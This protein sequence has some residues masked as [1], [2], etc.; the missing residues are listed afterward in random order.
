MLKLGRLLI[1]NFKSF[2]E[3]IE[4]DFS[5]QDLVLF[6]GP[7]GFGK[8]TI[9]DAVEL[10]LTGEIKRIQKT[11]SKVKREHVLKRVNSKKTSIILEVLDGNQSVITIEVRIDENI[12]GK[13]GKIEN[14]KKSVQRFEHSDWFSAT[15]EANSGIALEAGRLESILGNLSLESTFSI[16][17]YIQQEETLHFLKLNENERHAKIK[18]LFGTTDETK[19]LEKLASISD[20]LKIKVDKYKDSLETKKK[21]LALLSKP[22]TGDFDEDLKLNTEMLKENLDLSTSTVVQVKKLKEQLESIA[23]VLGNNQQFKTQKH[24]HLVRYLKKNRVKLLSKLIKIGYVNEYSKLEKLRN[25]YH[26]WKKSKA[27]SS[28]YEN[29]IKRYDDNPNAVTTEI[30][31]DFKLNFNREYRK[32]SSLIDSFN[33]LTSSCKLSGDLVNKI[34]ENRKNLLDNYSEHLDDECKEDKLNCPLCGKVKDDWD[35][36]IDEYYRQEE[37]FEKQLDDNQKKLSDVTQDLLDSF[38]S[39]QIDK[40]KRYR[41]RYKSYFEFDFDLLYSSKFLDK[42]EFEDVLTLSKWVLTNIA[43]IDNFL[44]KELYEVKPSYEETLSKLLIHIENSIIPVGSEEFKG[45]TELSSDIKE[46][47]F[48]FDTNGD[49]IGNIED[50]LID[51]GLLNKL[52]VQK[53]DLDYKLKEKELASLSKEM[54]KIKLKRK[55]V[56]DI[57][58]I[59]RNKIKEFERNIAKNIAIPLFVYSSKILQSR[60]EGSGIF[61]ITPSENNARSKGFMQFSATA[62]DSHDAWNTMSSGQLSGLVIS[63]MLAMNKVYPT[64]LFTL[65]IDDPVQTMDEVNMASFVQ[66]MRYEF[67]HVQLLISTH[68]PKVANYI[69]YKYRQAGLETSPINMKAKRLEVVNS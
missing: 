49:L 63:F 13:D 21:E 46:L 17:N 26:R 41:T 37:I 6:D 67:P 24:N 36:L 35:E 57:A 7:N 20:G 45:Y 1:E 53:S 59:Y 2:L 25:Q 14:Y 18:H 3:P 4:F 9:F 30:L 10:C 65:M 38:V 48:S 32:F 42:Q 29:I 62:S 55:E 22:T 19:K 64:N 51:I 68:E 54:E 69:T 34:I 56:D 40:L 28:L 8:T 11:D 50:I 44:D 16:F 66:M 58:N 39:P 60:P 52:I 61:L 5:K 47:K 23:W 12:S 31:E 27:K 33:D 43:G 15:S